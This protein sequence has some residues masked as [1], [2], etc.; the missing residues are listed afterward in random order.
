MRKSVILTA[1]VVAGAI[2]AATVVAYKYGTTGT[3][4][5]STAEALPGQPYQSVFLTNG[6]VYFGKIT[7]RT[8]EQTTLVDVYYLQVQQPIQPTDPNKK[9]EQQPQISLVKL[10][11]ELHKPEDEMTINNQQILFVE[12]MKEDGQ[13]VQAI[14][15]FQRGETGNT[16]PNQTNQTNQT[17]PAQ[18]TEKK[19]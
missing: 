2:T 6:Q 1:L 13:V 7:G 19:Q 16:N 10:G 18:P 5:E 8:S 17:A 14:R 3:K 12:K 9:V 11:N 4:K 15:R